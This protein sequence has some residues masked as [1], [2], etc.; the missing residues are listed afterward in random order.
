MREST[1]EEHLVHRTQMNGG[2][3]RKVKW[4]G[5]R[6]APDRLVLLPQQRLHFLVELKAT[7]KHAT[8]AQKREHNRLRAAG[9]TVHVW[10]SKAEIDLFFNNLN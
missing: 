7:G 6:S 8:L 10:N 3:V 4:I 1:I 9:M 2:D 5:R